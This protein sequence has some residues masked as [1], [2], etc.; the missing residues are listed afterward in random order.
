MN[1]ENVVYLEWIRRGYKV[2]IGKVDEVEVDF[3]SGMIYNHTKDKK[4]QGQSFPEFMQKI[5]AAEGLIAYINN[6]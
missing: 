3:D 2:Y 1:L 6:K 5:I 4:Y